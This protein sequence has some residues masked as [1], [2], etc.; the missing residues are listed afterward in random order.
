MNYNSHRTLRRRSLNQNSLPRA[1]W[2]VTKRVDVVTAVSS[3]EDLQEGR[4]SMSSIIRKVISTS[5]AP[6][7]IG[8]YR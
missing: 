2:S 7:A 6:A 3:L 8:A 1:V 5:K 4:I